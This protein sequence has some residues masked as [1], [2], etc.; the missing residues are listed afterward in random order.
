MQPYKRQYRELS[1]ETREKI[2]A[3]NRNRPK[4]EIHRQHISQAMK[5]YWKQVPFRPSS[6]IDHLSRLS[7]RF[8]EDILDSDVNPIR[9]FINDVVSEDA[10]A[11]SAC[12]TWTDRKNLAMLRD[13]DMD[14]SKVE[15]EIRTC[16][17]K[18][19]HL[20]QIIKPYKEL[21]SR[22]NGKKSEFKANLLGLLLETTIIF[23]LLLVW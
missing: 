4:S 9:D 15:A 2:A 6:G 12:L 21:W 1:D 22:L 10:E 5:D 3:A 20:S 18:G 11:D 8:F 13:C 19:S 14:L 16:A 7:F 17:S 23:P